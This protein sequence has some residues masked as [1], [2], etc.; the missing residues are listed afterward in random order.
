M[1]KQTFLTLLLTAHTRQGPS[2]PRTSEV[3]SCSNST[4]Q[5]MSAEDRA[6]APSQDGA[7]EDKASKRRHSHGTRRTDAA[8]ER[9]LTDADLDS[10]ASSLRDEDDPV[11]S[12][13]RNSSGR[14]SRNPAGPL[15]V[16]RRLRP[17]SRQRQS[18]RQD[19]IKQCQSK[20]RQ[21]TNQQVKALASTTQVLQPEGG[22]PRQ[23]PPIRPSSS[24]GTS[25]SGASLPLPHT[26]P[27]TTTQATTPM[28]GTDCLSGAQPCQPLDP[29]SKNFHTI[30][31][32]R[33]PTPRH[34]ADLD[35]H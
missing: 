11:E 14:A 25:T 17:R 35:H 7:R 21:P 15:Q 31:E 32:R 6:N 16:A 27:A 9:A 24:S 10:D 13:S 33:H 3:S 30:S 20:C 12:I 26:A 34:S 28:A 2:S 8:E 23:R 5:I 18:H 1:P 4:S 19:R 22:H 29:S